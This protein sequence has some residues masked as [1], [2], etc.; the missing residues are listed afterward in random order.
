MK[1]IPILYEDDEIFIVDKPTG[2]AVQGG[3]G[4][5]HPLDEELPKILRKKIFLVH[6][7]DRD[8]SGLLIVA[9]NPV[10]AS[11]WSALISGK[12][13]EKEYEAICFG[14]PLIN[15]KSEQSGTICIPIKKGART[16]FAKT[17][18]FVEETWSKILDEQK[19]EF[20]RVRLFLKTGRMH[21]IR[22]HLA[23]VHAP[24]VADDKHGDF[25]KNKLARKLGI[26]HLQLCARRLFIPI[27]G[28]KIKIEAPIPAH[29][30]KNEC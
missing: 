4:I 10:A 16:L 5:T 1:E 9:K 26:K 21:Q 7:L 11:K 8:T 18:F 13:V 3:A 6:R 29:F 22:I 19:M 20:S 17:E 27:G 30:F 24:I 14:S 2:V 28:K 23:A 12:T 25:K 15:G